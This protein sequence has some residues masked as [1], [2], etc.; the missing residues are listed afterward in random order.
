MC[1]YSTLR[2]VSVSGGG[3]WQDVVVCGWMCGR[4]RWSSV[5][6]CAA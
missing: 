5:V 1:D 2:A 3:V 4:I 6:G